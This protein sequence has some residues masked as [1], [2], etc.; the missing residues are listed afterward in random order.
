MPTI[1]GNNS[2][3]S[4]LAGPDNRWNKGSAYGTAV[5]VSFSF[6]KTLPAYA[7]PEDPENK[8]FS[9]FNAEQQAASR[10]IFARI[11][12]VERLLLKQKFLAIRAPAV[13]VDC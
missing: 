12:K 8:G 13:A 9:V 11:G 6:A 10:A 3:D 5:N 4:L 2:I 7:D 1:T